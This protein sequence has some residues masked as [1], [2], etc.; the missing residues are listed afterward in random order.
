ML[1]SPPREAGSRRTRGPAERRVGAR[2]SLGEVL[3]KRVFSPFKCGDH[4]LPVGGGQADDR[5]LRR[6][7]IPALRAVSVIR[8]FGTRSGLN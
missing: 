6:E 2:I 4:T 3:R 1:T 7:S 8:V 5:Q